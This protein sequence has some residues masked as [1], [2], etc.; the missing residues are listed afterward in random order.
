MS[1][2]DAVVVGAGSNGLAAAVE[3]AIADP[4]VRS[5]ACVSRSRPRDPGEERMRKLINIGTTALAALMAP[6]A[7]S[8]QDVEHRT[9]YHI[10]AYGGGYVDNWFSDDFDFDRLGP[11]FGLRFGYQDHPRL[12]WVL[13]V[14]IAT[15]DDLERRGDE[16]QFVIFGRTNV[17]A[18]GGAEYAGVRSGRLSVLLELLGGIVVSEDEPEEVV[19][20]DPGEDFLPA[21]NFT[22]RAALAPGTGVLYRIG[23]YAVHT[24]LRGVWVLGEGSTVSPELFAGLRLGF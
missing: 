10:E 17:V 14:A 8:G 19:G 18:L 3:L 23:R 13:D 9:P 21:D 4:P 16:E 24:G 20:F 2:P 15:V 5:A 12:N 11:L 7:L 22:G 6:A 1:R